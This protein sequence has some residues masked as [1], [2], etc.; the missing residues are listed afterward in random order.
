MAFTVEFSTRATRDVDEIVAY[1]QADSPTEATRWRQRLLAKMESLRTLPEACG[2]APEYA[3][4]RR[5]IRQLL[6]GQYRV[7]FEIRKESVF[8]VTIRHGAR[9]AMRATEIDE[10]D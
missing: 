9:R 5:E 3:L 4:A 1:I 10:I 6:F 8:V 2:L 7:L